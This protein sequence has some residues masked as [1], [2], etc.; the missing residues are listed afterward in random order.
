MK[1]IGILSLAL[2]PVFGFSQKAKV[3]TAWR[4]LNDY[5]ATVKD[6]KPDLVYL[7]KA[8]DAIDVALTHEDTKNQGK[9]HAYKARISYAFYQNALN[10]EL[11]KLEPTVQDKNERAMLAYGNTPLADFETANEEINKIQEVDPKFMETIKD[12]LTK[13]TSMLGEEDIKIAMV[14]QQIKMESANIAQGKYKAKKYDEA[15][16]Y[17]YKTAFLNTLLYKVKDTANFYNA[18]ISAGKAKNP[19]KIIDYNKKMIDSKIAT[20]YNYESMYNAQMSKLDTTAAMEILKKGRVAFPGDL[21]LMNKETDYYLAKGKQEEALNNLK[22]SIEKDPKNPVFYLISGQIYDG[23][24]NPKEKGTM[25]ELPKPA[26]YEECIKNAETYYQKGID[27]NSP[28]KEY[29]YNLIFNLGALYNNYG[30]Y[31]QNRQPA[32]I[33]EM[34]KTQKENEAKSQEA[35]KKAIPLL[36]QALAIKPDDRP[37]MIA[38][39]KLY[40]FTKQDDKAKDMNER[41]KKQ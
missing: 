3:Q 30:G 4:A 18:C 12:G 17:F 38:L 24:A 28:N 41:L 13:G 5:E 34:A 32:T 36:E 27:L 7:T 20:P 11:K 35:F 40:M 14:T 29:Q 22:V 8:K 26:N 2:L 6:G 19:T 33:T 16:D 15:A 9:T 1:K 39:R 10:A 31:Y 37:T 23:M 21:S 25:K